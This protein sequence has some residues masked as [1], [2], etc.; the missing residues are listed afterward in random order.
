MGQRKQFIE[1][2]TRSNETA[3]GGIDSIG[4]AFVLS[5]F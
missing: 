2:Q 5:P 4:S 3:D 1:L